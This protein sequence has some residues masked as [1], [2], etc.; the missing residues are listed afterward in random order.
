MKEWKSKLFE[1]ETDVLVKSI[2]TKSDGEGWSYSK[3]ALSKIAG[4]N[5]DTDIALAVMDKPME[6][7]YYLHRLSEKTCVL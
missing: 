4:K 5:I 7:N 1:F 2:L 6:L 3:K